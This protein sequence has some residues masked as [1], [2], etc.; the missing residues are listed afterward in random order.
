MLAGDKIIHVTPKRFC[1]DRKAEVSY[2]LEQIIIIIEIRKWFEPRSSIPL[3]FF[4]QGIIEI[5]R[6][7]SKCHCSERVKV[8]VVIAYCMERGS[9]N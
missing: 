9:Q 8:P 6:L 5:P 7:Q 3:I 1:I 4:N 2:V